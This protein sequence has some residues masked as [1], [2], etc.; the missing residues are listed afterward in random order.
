[1]ITTSIRE[2]FGFSFLEPWTAGRA[3]VGRRL[4]AVAPDF[5]RRGVD[6]SSLYHGISV[7]L[8]LIDSLRLREIW[9]KTILDLYGQYGMKEA[10]YDPGEA[11]FRITAGGK[12]DFAYLDKFT[13][14][15]L[16]DS[17]RKDETVRG[18]LVK[19]NTFLGTLIEPMNDGSL[20]ER[21]RRAVLENYSRDQYRVTLLDIYRKVLNRRVDQKIDKNKLLR[22]F[23][24]PENFLLGGM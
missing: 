15:G 1:M 14:R 20:I 9:T 16:I 4:E 5:E 6:L 8:D 24:S 10:P 11:W 19:E 12:V 17:C 7:P 13:A 21:N 2:G 3:V 23:L 18:L 22:S